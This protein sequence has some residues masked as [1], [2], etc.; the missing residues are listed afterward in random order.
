MKRRAP[1][2]RM[3]PGRNVGGWAGDAVDSVADKLSILQADFAELGGLYSDFSNALQGGWLSPA[4]AAAVRSELGFW[5]QVQSAYQN[6]INLVGG[7]SVNNVGIVPLI[8][9]GAVLV[10][11]AVAG[12]YIANRLVVARQISEQVN[13][14]QYA[15]LQAGG[16]I[17]Q[18][19]AAVSDI[20]KNFGTASALPSLAIIAAV[21]GGLWVISKFKK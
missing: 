3:V 13:S 10:T 18:A 6:V 9:G 16:I 5:P 11:L 7:G 12:A 8:V 20:F 15:Y 1:Y 21:L 17:P 14:E 2:L 19:G 4:T